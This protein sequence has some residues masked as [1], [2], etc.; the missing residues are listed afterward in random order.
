[1]KCKKCGR[2]MERKAAPDN[3]YY[4]ECPN[5]HAEIGKPAKEVEKNGGTQ[6]ESSEAESSS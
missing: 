6:Q 4:Y 2:T 1:M 5:C 3:V